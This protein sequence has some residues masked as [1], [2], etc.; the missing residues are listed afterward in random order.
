MSAEAVRRADVVCCT[1]SMAGEMTV[2]HHTFDMVLID[3][4][5]TAVEPE[6]LIPLVLGA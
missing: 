1:M 5:A 4:A 3:E 6:A 2:A